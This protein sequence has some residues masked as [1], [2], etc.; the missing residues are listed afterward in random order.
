LGHGDKCI[1]WF[2]CVSDVV[3]SPSVA[4]DKLGHRQTSVLDSD[5]ESLA[6]YMGQLSHMDAGVPITANQVS[7]KL[8]SKVAGQS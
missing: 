5:D 4:A 7:S 1:N 2:L 3:K 6:E 8:G